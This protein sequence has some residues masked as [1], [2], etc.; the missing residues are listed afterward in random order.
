MGDNS[1]IKQFIAKLIHLGSP[2][3][4]LAPSQ[5]STKEI[6]TEVLAGAVI[7]FITQ[8]HICPKWNL[9]L[10]VNSRLYV[11]YSHF[12]GTVQ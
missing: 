1:H 3:K 2:L 12:L 10:P 6:I 4:T 7:C 8:K 5:S 9:L 11:H